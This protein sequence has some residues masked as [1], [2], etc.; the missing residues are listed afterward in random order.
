MPGLRRKPTA[1]ADADARRAQV[2]ATAARLKAF[3]DA[4]ATIF[5]TQPPGGKDQQVTD[6]AVECASLQ[7]LVQ[8]ILAGVGRTAPVT[9]PV[10]IHSL[11]TLTRA[12]EMGPN[13]IQI[14]DLLVEQ[15]RILQEEKAKAK[16]YAT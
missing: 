14:A 4:E 7:P 10:R 12:E 3:Q 11:S 2:I 8:A 9:L 15:L 16:A 13:G 5:N 6:R 1:K